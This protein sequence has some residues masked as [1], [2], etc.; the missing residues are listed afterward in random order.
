MIQQRCNTTLHQHSMATFWL[1]THSGC[2]LLW[3]AA[4]AFHLLFAQS[5]CWFAARTLPDPAH[6]KSEELA[7]EPDPEQL[8][9][10]RAQLPITVEDRPGYNRVEGHS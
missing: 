3:T 8:K 4:A 2:Y 1:T 5:V 9:R 6:A 10:S 7:G